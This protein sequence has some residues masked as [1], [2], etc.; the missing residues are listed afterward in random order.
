MPRTKTRTHATL[1]CI[2]CRQRH[3][4][5]ERL[6]G[7]DI[8]TNCREYNRSCVSIPG[9]RRGPKSRRQNHEFANLQPFSNINPY[10][11]IQIQH[12]HPVSRVAHT[13]YQLTTG[14]ESHSCLTPEV[15]TQYQLTPSTESYSYL[16]PGMYQE[17]HT[18]SSL[19]SLYPVSGTTEAFQNMFI[20]QSSSASFLS[21]SFAHEESTLNIDR[22]TISPSITY[23]TSLSNP[24]YCFHFG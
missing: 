21:S 23:L 20:N 14:I 19:G 6:P 8:C 12:S 3:E 11:A 22:P 4:R 16:T 13:Q 10:S 7:K 15:C 18:P 2:N 5:C 17:Q 9:N 1:A 24:F